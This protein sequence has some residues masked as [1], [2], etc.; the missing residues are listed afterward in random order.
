MRCLTLVSA[1]LI[2][3]AAMTAGAP[4]RTA[5][6]QERAYIRDEI[7]VNMRAGPGLQFRILRVLTSGDVVRRLAERDD[8]LQV[9]IPGG[10]DGWIESGYVTTEL[11]PSVTLPRV[12]D[13]LT[14]AEARVRELER[15]LAAQTEAVKDLE[16][17]R[18]RN[19]ALEA[20]NA[21]LAFSSGWKDMAT[22]A[23]IIVVGMII[24]LLAPRGAS[25]A[26]R[27]IKL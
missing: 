25:R 7:R 6:A 26:G 27:K 4:A 9:R 8:W 21:D 15:K 24:G 10:P 5:G 12:Q 17:L 20:S 23:S 14:H 1:L 11:P 22:G 13:Q 2:A 19:E 16:Q 3:A 18:A